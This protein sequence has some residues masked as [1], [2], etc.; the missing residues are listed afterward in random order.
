MTSLYTVANNPFS[1]TFVDTSS[2]HASLEKG[3]DDDRIRA[4]TQIVYMAL[5]GDSQ[6]QLLMDIIRYVLPSKNRQLK[7]LLHQYWE[8]VPKVDA[9]G[10]LRQEMIL[11]VNAIRNDLQHP[12]EYIRGGTLR[13][14]TKFREAELLEPLVPTIRECLEHRNSY[15]RKNALFCI[16]AIAQNEPTAFLM[17]DA[18]DVI[19]A[20]LAL[21]RDCV[22]MRNGFVA[23]ASLNR[24]LA[25]AYFPYRY[26]TCS[27]SML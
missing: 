6:S 4:M 21:E 1:S 13:F 26:A 10:K 25:Y 19:S 5:A 15:V 22:C 11:V 23:L 18:S 12:N 27:A 20:P 16:L 2:L 24:D 8:A 3:S 17:P 7:K 14:L 9:H